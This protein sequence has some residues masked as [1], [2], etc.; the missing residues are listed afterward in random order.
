MKF[1]NPCGLLFCT[2]IVLCIRHNVHADIDPFEFQLYGYGT[3]GKGLFD[4]ELLSR[5]IVLGHKEGEG[6]SPTFASQ[7]MMYYAIEVEYGLTDK[8]D[9]AFYLNLAHPDGQDL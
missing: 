2:L 7:D 6:M 1:F 3:E 4:S 5:Y 9:F 8:I